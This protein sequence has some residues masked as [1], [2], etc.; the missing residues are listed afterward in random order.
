MGL[1]LKLKELLKEWNMTIKELSALSGVSL[2]TLY[3]ITKRDN[4]LARYDI[5]E[6]L[7]RA[8]EVF[9]GDLIPDEK[10]LNSAKF[11]HFYDSIKKLSNDEKQKEIVKFFDNYAAEESLY[12]EK[13]ENHPDDLLK[14]M[15]AY[16]E[17]IYVIL[18]Q[19]NDSG[20]KKAL[21]QME[22]LTKIPEYRKDNK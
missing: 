15:N 17:K 20:Q 13:N 10:L 6:K 7:A 3:S 21:E 8:L 11:E 19:L 4:N 12:I 5:I 22:L 16:R 9:P 18:S 2:N 1:G 14:R